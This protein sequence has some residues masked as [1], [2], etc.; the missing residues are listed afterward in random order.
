MTPCDSSTN[1]V[2]LNEFSDLHELDEVNVDRP[3][4]P[5]KLRVAGIAAALSRD[6]SPTAAVV[7]TS[8]ASQMWW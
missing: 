5:S 3:R 1:L 6:E 4:R 8:M 7:P 2:Q